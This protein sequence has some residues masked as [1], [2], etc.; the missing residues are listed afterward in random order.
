[1]TATTS[2]PR[3]NPATTRP[4]E[5]HGA[6]V[7]QRIVWREH[8]PHWKVYDAGH[9]ELRLITAPGQWLEVQAEEFA[10]TG[11]T[12]RTMLTLHGDEIRALRDLCN[13]ALGE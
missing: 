11:A 6:L 4:V 12:K 10:S 9:A 5:F 3:R 13:T 8:T 7:E 1:M 2:P